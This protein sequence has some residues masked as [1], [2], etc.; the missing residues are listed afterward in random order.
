MQ[1]THKLE[2]TRL[3]DVD[4]LSDVINA[5]R[6][7]GRDLAGTATLQSSTEET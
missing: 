1:T 6:I 4:A 3:S 2:Q 5:I 7:L